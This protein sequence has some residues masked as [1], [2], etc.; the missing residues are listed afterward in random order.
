MKIIFVILTII[1]A[2]LV[3]FQL[4][5]FTPEH[6]K[7][8]HNVI[9]IEQS[10]YGLIFTEIIVNQKKV[11]AMIDFGDPHVLQLSSTLVENAKITVESTN[12]MMAD[13]A[14]NTFKLNKGVAKEV[15]VG[16]WKMDDVK[17]ASAPGEMESVSEQINTEF[18]AVVGWGYF[19]DKYTVVDYKTN[20]FEVY[21]KKPTFK[22][23]V[24]ETTYD[25]SSNYLLIP[26]ELNQQKISLL[27]DTGSPVTVIDDELYKKKKMQLKV[28]NKKVDVR[29]EKQ[30]LSVLEP[31]GAVG[32]IGGDF[33]QQY[34]MLIDPF[35]G[36][37]I[38]YNHKK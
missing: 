1:T 35:E 21:L 20:Q 23:A 34:R 6:E 33:I 32:I 37:M 5:N 26:A 4:A 2:N 11:K 10:D 24:F 12:A 9:K 3:G 15:I 30:D 8:S 36:N 22:K 38:F 16:N 31:L 7:Q 17:F 18:N 19:A 27:M 25:K 28:G 14:G 29:L 13:I